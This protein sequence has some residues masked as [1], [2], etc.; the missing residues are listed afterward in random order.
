MFYLSYV[1][2]LDCM[3]AEY[4]TCLVYRIDQLEGLYLC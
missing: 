3:V 4:R 2:S 1:D